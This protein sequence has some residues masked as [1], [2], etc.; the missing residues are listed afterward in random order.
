[1]TTQ[2]LRGMANAGSMH[3]RGDRTGGNDSGG[4]AFDDNA[5]FLKFQ[6]AFVGLLGAAN[7]VSN[8]QMQAFA[9]FIL[10]VTY[11]PNPVRALDNSLNSDQAAGKAFMTGS[12]RS[13][14]APIGDTLGFNC[15]GCHTLDPSQG[16]FGTA[17]RASFEN[18]P[19]IM[20]IP[21]FR[22][23]YQKVGMFGAAAVPAVLI[24]D[25]GH[26]GNQ[27][28]GFGFLHDGSND[29]LFRFFRANVF[30]GLPPSFIGTG[31]TSDTQRRQVVEFVMATDS[32]LAPIV[33]Q[34]VTLD[35]TN[36]AVAGP[37]ISLLIARANA[38]YPVADY[39]GARECDL[40]V[41][42]VVAGK[43]KGWTLSGS[44][45]VPDDGG[46][47]LTDAQLRALAATAG[48]SLTY[49]CAPPGSGARVGLDRD[50]DGRYDGVDNCVAL[51]NASQTDGD[52]DGVGNACD[53][54]A[55]TSNASQADSDADGL[56]DACDGA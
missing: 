4:S 33:G 54:C 26:K 8:S 45:F 28:R 40:V 1:M 31:F 35:N 51:K 37:R 27:I 38:A 2:S 16:Y 21:H 48:Q 18:E 53:N 39:P 20:K 11:P 56:G 49:T 7:T 3:W 36:S 29:T 22:N 30:S 41:K 14:G 12:R 17:G 34:Q 46:A 23:A 42:G 9:D 5:A 50:E 10:Q 6:P 44:S 47:A 19:Q 52:G 32:N 25:N 24:G 15:V 13:D 55:T 43:A